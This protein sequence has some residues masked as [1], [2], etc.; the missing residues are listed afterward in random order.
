MANRT[1]AFV[2]QRRMNLKKTVEAVI[3][4][5]DLIVFQRRQGPQ[6]TPF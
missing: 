4:D 6:I 5:G 2:K 3:E 1:A